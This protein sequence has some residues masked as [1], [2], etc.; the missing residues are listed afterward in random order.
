MSKELILTIAVP[1]YNRK[2]QIRKQIAMILPQLSEEVCLVVRDNNSSYNIEDLFD[3]TEKAK[4]QILHNPM[5]IGADANIARCV[6]TCTTKW[7]WVLGDDDFVSEEAVRK[8][9]EMIKLYDSYVWINLNTKFDEEFVGFQQFVENLNTISSFGDSFWIS[10]CIYNMEKLRSEMNVYYA[11]LSSMIPQLIF[12][13]SYLI[14]NPSEKIV[15]LK[16]NVFT[17][18]DPNIS[19]N[20]RDYVLNTG[21]IFSSFP[22][23]QKRFIVNNILK[24]L[25]SIH[26]SCINLKMDDSRY[27]FRLVVARYGFYN[28]IRSFPL[29][30]IK[31]WVRS[32]SPLYIYKIYKFMRRIL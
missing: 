12:L 9:L 29:L 5:N 31:S 21:L 11:N 15:R 24:T 7:L 26:L 22:S 28:L 4:F 16:M 1:T 19:W 13:L 14:K 6:E 17:Y 23:N 2:E 3:S 32:C 25:T 8:V 18:N 27:I 30:F 10:K 20:M